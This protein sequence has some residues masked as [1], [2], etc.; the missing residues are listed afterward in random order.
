[1]NLNQISGESE[2]N[3]RH[4]NGTSNWNISLRFYRTF[5]GLVACICCV[6]ETI[7]IYWKWKLWR[8]NSQCVWLSSHLF[9]ILI[10]TYLLECCWNR[11]HFAAKCKWVISVQII[12]VHMEEHSICQLILQIFFLMF[13][14]LSNLNKHVCIDFWI[15]S[16]STSI[17][18]YLST[19]F[20]H[21]KNVESAEESLFFREQVCNHWIFGNISHARIVHRPFRR[22]HWIRL[23]SS[24]PSS[25]N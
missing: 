22:V 16:M 25:S 11:A 21:L 24:P 23:T 1:M 5:Y 2:I 14:W 4:T 17:K 6:S 10:S 20:Y 7:F 9:N 15:R 12:S 19:R 8:V 13:V 18:R 3:H